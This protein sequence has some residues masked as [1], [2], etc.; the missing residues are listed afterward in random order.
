MSEQ[1]AIPTGERIRVPLNHVIRAGDD[2]QMRL[3]VH[4]RV[5]HMNVS[6]PVFLSPDEARDLAARL[7]EA[8]A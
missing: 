8:S 4:D 2:V 5:A 6:L 3:L 1:L 7:V